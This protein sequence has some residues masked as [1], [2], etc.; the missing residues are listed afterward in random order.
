MISGMNSRNEKRHNYF[1]ESAMDS[2]NRTAEAAV[3]RFL[4]KHKGG[5]LRVVV[6]Y[7]SVW[8]LAWLSRHCGGRPV[9]LLIGNCQPHWFK[10]STEEDREEAIRFLKREDVTLSNWF[11]SENNK[12]I[13]IKAWYLRNETGYKVMSG[14][15]NLTKQGMLFNE[16]FLGEHEGEEAVKLREQL[17]SL[18]ERAKD[19]KSRVLGYI[20]DSAREAEEDKTPVLAKPVSQQNNNYITPLAYTKNIPRKTGNRNRIFWTVAGCLVAAVGIAVILLTADSENNIDRNIPQTTAPPIYSTAI[21]ETI[22]A[23]NNS[24]PAVNNTEAILEESV[25]CAEKGR[26]FSY[27]GSSYFWSETICHSYNNDGSKTYWQCQRIGGDKC[28]GGTMDPCGRGEPGFTISPHSVG[29][30]L[31]REEVQPECNG[32]FKQSEWGIEDNRQIVS[33]EEAWVSGGFEWN[34]WSIEDFL[35]DTEKH[36]ENGNP[37]RAE[38]G[39]SA[40]ILSS[41]QQGTECEL[42]V[43]WAS[44]K[45][46][47][48]LVADKEESTQLQNM[49]RRYC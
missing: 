23:I 32:G 22:A 8:G 10:K 16:E 35:S 7:A 20:Y 6:G 28:F 33:A 26:P 4:D 19:A 40:E 17:Q 36:W 11:S 38:T 1:T 18:F 21:P 9:D 48:N 34:S 39:T 25:R 46:K 44:V 24:A 12:T 47:H 2:T 45:R 37:W 15:A 43:R 3:L 42:A 27:D 29:G 13:H 41:A 30:I 49:V 31:V 5:K 14:S